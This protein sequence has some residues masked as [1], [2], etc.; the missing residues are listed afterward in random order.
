MF[1]NAIA[2][3]FAGLYSD[4][5]RRTVFLSNAMIL[6]GLT[7][8]FSGITQDFNTFVALR[9]AFGVISA[10]GAPASLSLIRDFFPQN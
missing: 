1:P 4:Q 8:V 2:G 3:I 7:I 6:S 9:I 10:A 5:N